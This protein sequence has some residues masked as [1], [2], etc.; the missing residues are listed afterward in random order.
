MYTE[1]SCRERWH[2]ILPY[3]IMLCKANKQ[4]WGHA[5]LMYFLA[6]SQ[7][8]FWPKMIINITTLLNSRERQLHIHSDIL[9]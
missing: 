4:Q 1:F 6:T 8:L 7:C 3:Y 2:L 5:T 9:T